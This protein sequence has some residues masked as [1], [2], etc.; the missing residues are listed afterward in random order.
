MFKMV[1]SA[2]GGHR[3]DRR[4]LGEFDTNKMSVLC[5][6]KLLSR[7]KKGSLVKCI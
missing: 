5:K 7:K 6:Y 2:C 1:L 4:T 3:P